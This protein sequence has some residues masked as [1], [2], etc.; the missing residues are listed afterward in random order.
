MKKLIIL[1]TLVS[2]LAQ[3]PPSPAPATPPPGEGRLDQILKEVDDLMWNLKAGDIAEVDK[4][5]YTSAPPAKQAKPDLP[6]AKIRSSSAP[7]PSFRKTS[8]A[9]ANSLSLCLPTRAFTPTSIPA[10][11][12]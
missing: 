2:A 8:I 7:I 3:S 6:G 12:T 4:I 5:E 1:A 11:C 10:I 9:A